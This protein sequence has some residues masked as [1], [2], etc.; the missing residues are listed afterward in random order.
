MSRDK[1][2]GV[3]QE[4]NHPSHA[5]KLHASDYT[6]YIP[7]TKESQVLGR[8]VDDEIQQFYCPRCGKIADDIQEHGNAYKCGKCGLNRQSFGNA[9][10]VW[11]D[12]VVPEAK[13]ELVELKLQLKSVISSALE[14]E[15]YETINE[16][17][18]IFDNALKN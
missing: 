18:Q 7:V 10:Y 1:L 11:D 3:F 9:L 13:D 4:F 6:K 5:E 15:D 8:E 12:G 16:L 2:I 17:K 14:R